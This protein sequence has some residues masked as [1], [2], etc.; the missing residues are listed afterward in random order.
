[1]AHPIRYTLTEENM[2]VLKEI[3]K[4]LLMKKIKKTLVFK[5]EIPKGKWL[6]FV[7]SKDCMNKVFGNISINNQL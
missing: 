7:N 1:M 4:N 2:S 5:K 3:V 6:Y